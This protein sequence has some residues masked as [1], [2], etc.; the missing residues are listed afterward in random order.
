MIEKGEGHQLQKD[1]QRENL[2][3]MASFAENKHLCRRVQLMEVRHRLLST[4]R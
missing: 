3:L 4:H 1:R 2:R